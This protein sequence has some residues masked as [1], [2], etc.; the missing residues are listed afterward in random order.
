MFREK[1]WHEISDP[2]ITYFKDK[3][4]DSTSDNNTDLLVLYE[5]LV[6]SLDKKLN[7]LKYAILTVSA[8]RQHPDLEEAIK[9]LEEARLRLDGEPDAQML[10]RIS[11]AEKRLN[12]G[13][14]HDC[15][16]ILNEVKEVVEKEADINS[17][18][19][20]FLS[21]VFSKYYRRKQD[22]ENFYKAALQFLAYTSE[23][24]LSAEEKKQWS[25]QMGMAVLLGKNIY[26]IAEL[27]DKPLL[28][29]LVATDFQWLYDLLI[30][31]GKG[32]ISE[33]Q[34]AIKK[35][36]DFI[37]RFPT[38]MKE[39]SYLEQKVR[40]MA[41]LEMIFVCKKD[42]RRLSFDQIAEVCK[43]Q[44][45]QVELLVMKAM[46]LD[47]VRGSIDEVERSVDVTWIMPRYLNKEHLG[48]LVTR[49]DEWN[50]KMDNVIK[51]TEDGAS[52]LLTQ[53]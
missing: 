52:E 50:T 23:A 44:Q 43:V 22:Q 14:H 35:H 51:F 27:L 40:I 7:P 18:V 8:S 29:S 33:F 3:A 28:Q 17:K 42:E 11:M 20:A 2:L 39:M 16:D 32:H 25:I 12:L 24:D 41:F 13:Q 21:E 10:C 4:H 53:K 6:R 30:T 38:I 49:L 48:V 36:Q 26:N 5:S 31:L 15:I 19:Y 45:E 37:S 9:F 47:L 34:E 1:L 46:S